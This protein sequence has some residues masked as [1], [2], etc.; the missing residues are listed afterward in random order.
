MNYG[1]F[2]SLDREM[3]LLPKGVAVFRYRRVKDS[4]GSKD[5]MSVTPKY[6]IYA[7][8][9]DD[10]VRFFMHY[11]KDPDKSGIDCSE[12]KMFLFSNNLILFLP[13]LENT[14]TKDALTENLN[15]IF[16]NL[17]PVSDKGHNPA[18]KFVKDG[19]ENTE[20]K[21]KGITYSSLEVFG[22]VYQPPLNVEY[23]PIKGFMRK[24]FLDFLYDLE[25]SALFHNA[26]NF[27]SIYSKLNEN[28]LFAAI[29][30]KAEYY[31]Q[32]KKQ[33]DVHVVDYPWEMADKQLFYAEYYSKAEQIWVETITHPKADRCFNESEW[34]SDVETEMNQIYLSDS[35]KYRNPTKKWEHKRTLESGYTK[36]CNEYIAD[37]V[38]KEDD[39]DD[40]E[41]QNISIRKLRERLE[42][43]AKT[44]SNWYIKKYSFSGTIKIWYGQNYR[45]PKALVVLFILGL[46]AVLLAPSTKI[47]PEQILLPLGLVGGFSLL[48]LI[49]FVN[50]KKWYIRS[51]GCVNMLM[52]RLFASII[53]AWFTLA[54]GEDIF[55]GFFD[56]KH[57]LWV[58]VVLLAVLI[59]FVYYEIGKINPYI[60]IGKQVRRSLVL[61][62]V[63]FV[64]A[65]TA[66][67]L[68]ISFFGAKYLERSDYID[69][70]YVNK[71]YVANPEFTIKEDRRDT[72]VHEIFYNT[73]A[74]Y[75]AGLK[76]TIKKLKIGNIKYDTVLPHSQ[77]DMIDY[78]LTLLLVNEFIKGN[79]NKD[80]VLYEK[81]FEGSTIKGR[82]NMVSKYVATIEPDDSF[83]ITKSE[84]FNAW[85][86]LL[87]SIDNHEVYRDV[88]KELKPTENKRQAI[89]TEAEFG[90]SI[91]RD[92]LLQFTFFAMFIGIFIQ[93][94]FEDKSIT[95]PV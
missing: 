84:Y 37:I 22:I 68:V 59:I 41:R 91:F 46:S 30:N 17:Y 13:I 2:F 56:N 39:S 86:G 44:A 76:D 4:D 57:Q 18:Y 19:L 90:I 66:G 89:L 14:E 73:I 71:V 65:F 58:S 45:W 93:L 55:K 3:S 72:V 92:M 47:L 9:S 95:E 12:E 48:W 51:I 10:G 82:L 94:I 42:S 23:P 31:Y 67:I 78:K 35:I 5:A 64:Y 70:F 7:T 54:I 81:M 43:S 29:R 24:L 63:A 88:L 85:L 52:P 27:E 40:C 16:N 34:F 80:S 21:N 33:F 79:I 83:L 61:M 75:N 60:T 1:R 20:E 87:K 77:F 8:F 62:I 28:F 25:H 26:A 36:C 50:P 11:C 74:K 38:I 69:E 53:A 49:G 6:P 15:Q 32:R